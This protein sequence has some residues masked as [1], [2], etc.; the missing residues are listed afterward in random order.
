MRGS[1]G[2]P[3]RGQG[4]QRRQQRVYIYKDEGGREG[5]G[6]Q[7]NIALGIMAPCERVS[8]L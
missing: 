4:E 3:G 2:G 6:G 5:G 8:K 1:Q 7:G